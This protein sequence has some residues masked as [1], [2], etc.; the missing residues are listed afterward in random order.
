[1]LSGAARRPSRVV[2]PAAMLLVLAAGGAL[3]VHYRHTTT[4][5]FTVAMLTVIASA[6]VW[7]LTEVEPV[8]PIVVGLALSVFSGNWAQLGIPLGL[9]RPLLLYGIAAVFV[10]ALPDVRRRVLPPMTTLRWWLL[11]LGLYA[12]ISAATAGTLTQH[13]PLFALLDQFGLVG[14]ALFALA[15][16][17]FVRER[18]RDLLLGMLVVLGA[19]LGWVAF[20]Q[21]VHVNAL[22]YPRYITNPALG[23]HAGRARGPFLEAVANGLALYACGVAAATGYVR[24]RRRAWVRWAC[25]AVI[26][27]SVLGIVFTVTREVWIGSA[28]ATLVALSSNRQSR[29]Y[30]LPSIIVGAVLVVGALALVPGLD[31]SAT[32]RASDASPVWDRLNSD[33]AGLRMVEARPLFGF[34]WYEFGAKSLPYYRQASGYPLTVVARI[35]NVFLGFAVDLGLVGFGAWLGALLTAL[36]SAVRWRGPP[37]SEIWRV[38]LIAVATDWLIVA[39]FTPLGYA[40]PNHL[41][42]L[43]PGVVLSGR[44]MV[45]RP[46]EVTIAD[47][48][49]VAVA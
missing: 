45:V 20:F 24:W 44:S 7:A 21:G 2:L 15:P 10:Q 29:R 5:C 32:S 4:K 6:A 47:V 31:V 8:Y 48:G 43:W 25:L 14:F 28:V 3:A 33:A 34:G 40:F 11:A 37:K 17:I 30:V 16:A 49:E 19:Y 13:D 36:G 23:I 26:V 27:L 41:I 12:T 38:G 1:M 18:D 39:N 9:D 46:H 22:I 35:H 42:W